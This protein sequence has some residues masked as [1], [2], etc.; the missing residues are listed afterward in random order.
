MKKDNKNLKVWLIN[1]F[2]IA[3]V[4]YLSSLLY[5]EDVVFGNNLISLPLA[6]IFNALI[7]TGIL[8]LIKPI[9]FKLK[10]KKMNDMYWSLSYAVTNIVVI[11]LL[12][13]FA[14]NTGFGISSF[15]VAVGLGLVLTII[16]Y[17]LWKWQ[18]SK[19]KR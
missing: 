8:A 4:L 16:Q 3:L 11:W 19:M 15:I 18:E 13:K 2:T 14:V 1:I 5:P 10:L 17:F 7:L 9:L 12:A 6:I